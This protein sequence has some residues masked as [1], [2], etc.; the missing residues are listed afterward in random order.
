LAQRKRERE[1]EREREG[2]CLVSL[3]IT[4]KELKIPLERPAVGGCEDGN[5]KQ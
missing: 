5:R 4:L 1:R 2:V 3:D